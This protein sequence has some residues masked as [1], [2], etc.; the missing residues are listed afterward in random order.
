MNTDMMS[1][2]QHCR[3]ESMNSTSIPSLIWQ[4][5][6]FISSGLRSASSVSCSFTSLQTTGTPMSMTTRYTL[7]VIQYH[8]RTQASSVTRRRWSKHLWQRIEDPL[9]LVRLQ[10]VVICQSINEQALKAETSQVKIRTMH[11]IRKE[12]ASSAATMAWGQAMR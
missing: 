1:F 3:K 4:E 2:S 6:Y 10:R 8:S 5:S 11:G 12:E 7:D 9:L